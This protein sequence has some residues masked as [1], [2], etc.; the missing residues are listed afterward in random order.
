MRYDETI[1]VPGA[2]RLTFEF[3]QQCH[4]ESGCDI[5]RFYRYPE[6]VEQLY[7]HSGRNFPPLEVDG[8]TV[9]L[10]F[11]TDSSCTE[12]GYKFRVIPTMKSAD[13]TDP[14]SKKACIDNAMWIL[15]M[16]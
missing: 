4:T 10:Y 16:V 2:A 13:T 14:L 6:H 15:E 9:Y 7:E 11:Y 1:H 8:D 3:D 5:L 12:W